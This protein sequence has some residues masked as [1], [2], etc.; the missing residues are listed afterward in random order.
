LEQ[1][2]VVLQ[3]IF[4]L[5]DKIDESELEQLVVNGGTQLKQQQLISELQADN[6]EL[7]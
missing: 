1:T 6:K 3:K 5:Q 7:K 2:L 4:Q